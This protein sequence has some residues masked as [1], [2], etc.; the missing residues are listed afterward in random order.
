VGEV[1]A[2]AGLP[3]VVDVMQGGADE[4]DDGRERTPTRRSGAAG[5]RRSA[6][7]LCRAICAADFATVDGATSG[8][9]D[10]DRAPAPRG[11]ASHSP[12]ASRGTGCGVTTA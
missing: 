10:V 2:V 1:A 6:V 11:V 3:F 8:H 7:V 4:A 5:A 9:D 12:G